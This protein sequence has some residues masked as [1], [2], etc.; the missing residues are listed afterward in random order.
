MDGWEDEG[1]RAGSGGEGTGQ[2]WKHVDRMGDEIS[3]AW[4][5]ASCSRE[6]GAERLPLIY[7]GVQRNPSSE[8]CKSMA[9]WP[10]SRA[11]WV[12]FEG[13]GLGVD[14]Q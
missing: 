8:A 7:P 14:G 13:D 6:M 3:G 9:D 4:G 11:R 2:V 1:C 10:R 12:D 5:P